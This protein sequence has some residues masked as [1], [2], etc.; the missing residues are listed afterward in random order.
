MQTKIIES[1]IIIAL[2]IIHEYMC[3]CRN[4]D[5]IVHIA[6]VSHCYTVFLRQL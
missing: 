4:D 5:K 6:A 3:V 2:H 1:V